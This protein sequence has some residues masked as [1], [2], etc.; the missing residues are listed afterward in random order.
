[1]N[2]PSTPVFPLIY[3]KFSLSNC[4]FKLIF[5]TGFPLKSIIVPEIVVYTGGYTLIL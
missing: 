2:F 5:L 3:C 1:M 4:K